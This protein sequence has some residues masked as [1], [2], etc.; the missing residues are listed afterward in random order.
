MTINKNAR[1]GVNGTGEHSTDEM[2]GKDTP[3]FPNIP[4]GSRLSEPP[5]QTKEAPLSGFP[6]EVFENLPPL[7]KI[8]CDMFTD[9]TEREVFLLGALAVCSGMLPSLW[10][11]YD[12]QMC[13]P[14]LYVFLIAPYGAGKGSLKYARMLGQPIHAARLEASRKALAQWKVEAAEAKEAKQPEP[15]KPG[16]KML[17][18]PANNSKSG[19]IELLSDNQGAGGIIFETEGDTLADA[20]KSDHGNFSD[21][22]RKA[23]HHEPVTMYRRTDNE[24]RDITE[25]RLAVLLSGTQDQYLKLIPDAQNGLFSRFLHYQLKHT[26]IFKN[27]FDTGKREYWPVIGEISKQ[28]H[29][30]CAYL[31]TLSNPIEF[32]FKEHQVEKFYTTFR[33]L[34]SDIT[35]ASLTDLDGCI[36]RLGL[37]T[38]RLAMVL[39]ALRSFGEADYSP[40]IFCSDQDF[41]N[42]HQIAQTAFG[43]GLR[44][45]WNLNKP[46]AHPGAIDIEQE[47]EKEG[48]KIAEV[49]RLHSEG[50]PYRD[51][52]KTVFGDRSDGGKQKVYRIIKTYC[53]GQNDA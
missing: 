37:I 4:P 19:F 27:V 42:A 43:H 6:Y 41:E 9:Q 20:L 11:Y 32:K 47:Q 15:E 48:D 10:G 7:L 50:A 33:G 2:S 14:Q 1:T 35:G 36:N 26:P 49:L 38:F 5:Q 45:F 17:F 16:Q 39:A 46:K 51:I 22:L 29:G 18:L 3:F 24:S 40:H 21:V 28:L 44:T 31:E 23:F 53:N 25:P 34:K 12:G 30:C 13:G 8:P 52:A